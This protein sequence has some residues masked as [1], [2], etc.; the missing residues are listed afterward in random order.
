MELL[1]ATGTM[2]GLTFILAILLVLAYRKLSVYEDKRIGIVEELLPKNNC[3]ACGFAS[4]AMFAE[5][6]VGGEAVPGSCT[7]STEQDKEKIAGFLGVDVGDVDRLVARLACAGGSNV[8]PYRAQYIGVQTC[9]AAAQIAGGGKDCM[10]GCLGMGDCEVSCTFDAIHMNQHDLPIVDE[11]LCTAC[12][13]CIEACPKDLFSLQSVSNH[14]WVTCKNEEFGDQIL[15]HCQV[16]CTACE[17]CAVDEPNAITMQHNLPVVDYSKT[18]KTND[19][20][21]RCPT[22]AIVWIEIDGSV[23]YGNETK[24]VFRKEKLHA[25][26][27]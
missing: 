14:L 5:A 11:G 15:E 9:A 3:G 24:T 19:A 26:A 22:G 27:T 21:Q 18:V 17:K 8:A 2:L 20:I 7:V 23:V 25:R 1:T 12:N 4:C 6:L 16:A 10:W 13:D